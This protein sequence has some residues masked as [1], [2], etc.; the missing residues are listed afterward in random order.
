MRGDELLP[1]RQDFDFGIV[2]LGV[3]PDTAIDFREGLG[4]LVEQQGLRREANPLDGVAAQVGYEIDDLGD[5]GRIV[6]VDID[7][8]ILFRLDADAVIAFAR[9]DQSSTPSAVPS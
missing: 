3:D 7:S 9:L 6:T 8:R 4:R 2:A 5:N 1:V